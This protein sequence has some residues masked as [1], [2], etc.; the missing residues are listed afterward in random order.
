MIAAAHPLVAALTTHGDPLF[1]RGVGWFV[2]VVV[3]IRVL[4]AFAVLLTAVILM[5]WFE[6]KVISD[7]QSRIGPN[8]AGPWGMLQTMADGIKLIF[9]EDLMPERA[10]RFV[11]KLAPFLSLVPAM[12]V[13]TVVPIGGIIH[14][15]GHA[16]ELQVADP[17]IGILLVLA[18]SAIG[19]YGV[20]LAGWSS[21]S[22]YPLLGSV[23]ASAQMISYE[24][25][26]GITVV[27]VVLITGS[28]STRAIVESQAT[29]FWD[30]NLIRLGVV[31]FFIFLIAITAELTRPPFN[32]TEADSELVGGFHTEYSSFRFA[33]FYLAEYMSV[34]T[35][36]AIMVTLFFG[37]PDGPVP[38]LPS[39]SI[40]FPVV[41]FL[42]KVML[43]LFF[44]VWLGAALPRLR[45]D[46]LMTV[47]WKYLI[48]LSLGWLMAVAG[49]VADR[50]WGL[51]IAVAAV[52]LAGVLGRAFGIGRERDANE[53]A[54]L[55]PVGRRPLLPNS[56]PPEERA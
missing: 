21:G 55:R 38:H 48:P 41:W 33:I 22:K 46:Q 51:G 7:M 34:I 28:L 2:W 8:R 36:S 52:L 32:L 1:D 40:W 4:V 20:M 42:G 9:K 10:D 53:Q 49:F 37:G 43:F 56:L 16:F 5:I 23:R 47:G 26:L 31:P 35:M 6:R 30:W 25:A 15:S 29:N 17:P 39:F 3:V 18:M 27:T 50:W 45:Y 13:F 24:A 14:I 54:I 11:F 12:I 44:Y 19:V